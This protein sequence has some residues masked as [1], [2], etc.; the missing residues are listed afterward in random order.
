MGKSCLLKTHVRNP[1]G[2]M[3]ESR[4]F[5]DLLNY[6]PSRTMAVEYYAVGTN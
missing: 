4:L 2:N 6:L 1:Q 5:N 3:V